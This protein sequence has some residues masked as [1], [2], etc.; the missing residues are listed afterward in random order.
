MP[1]NFPQN[2]TSSASPF[3]LKGTARCFLLSGIFI[4]HV[5][6]QT[7]WQMQWSCQSLQL[8]SEARCPVLVSFA[9]N[10]AGRGVARDALQRTEAQVED[11]VMDGEYRHAGE[12]GLSLKNKR[13]LRIFLDK[14]FVC[15]YIDRCDAVT[16]I[17]K[18]NLMSVFKNFLGHC[19]GKHLNLRGSTSRVQCVLWCLED[20]I[21]S[22]LWTLL[23][24]SFQFSTSGGF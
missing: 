4:S 10:G 2:N 19:G 7:P 21:Q 14:N 23:A 15:G 12:R 20:L 6:F 11:Q 1:C 8:H 3:W 16:F 17:Q 9:N 24:Q 22:R 5:E 13:A 18:S